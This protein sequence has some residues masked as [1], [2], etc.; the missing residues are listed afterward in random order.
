MAHFAKLD[1]NNIVIS[2]HAL[3]NHVTADSEGVEDENIGVAYLT[4]IHNHSNW[5]QT[6]YNHNFRKQYCGIGYTYDSAKDKFIEP[7]PFPSWSL[8]ENDDWNAPVTYPSIT[9]YIPEGQSEPLFYLI[10]WDEPGQKWTAYDWQTPQ[11]SFNWNVDT[12][13]WDSV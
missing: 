7:Q 2:V 4:K 9:S 5:K 12:G 6:S 1:E 3:D 8:D 10:N 13:S 11:G